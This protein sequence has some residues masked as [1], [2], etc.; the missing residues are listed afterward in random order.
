MED[1]IPPA[2]RGETE[3]HAIGRGLRVG[4]L[5]FLL[6]AV[7]TMLFLGNP[8]QSRL[9]QDNSLEDQ[10]NRLRGQVV[11]SLLCGAGMGLTAFFIG[12]YG[13]YTGMEKPGGDQTP[14]EDEDDES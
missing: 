2:P 11:I 1:E 14:T 7:A 10:T 3:W 4:F 9:F 5:W 13:G 8:F 6:G 12:Y